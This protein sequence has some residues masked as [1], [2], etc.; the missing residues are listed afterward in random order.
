M[1]VCGDAEARVP[2]SHSNV[3]SL[4]LRVFGPHQLLKEPDPLPPITDGLVLAIQR[5][6]PAGWNMHY[7]CI[8]ICNRGRVYSLYMHVPILWTE[9]IDDTYITLSFFAAVSVGWGLALYERMLAVHLLM[10]LCQALCQY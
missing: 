1:S 7:V 10:S 3:S 9:G 6:E 2:G 5:M 4:S 8:I